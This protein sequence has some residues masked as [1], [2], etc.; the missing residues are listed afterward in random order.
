MKLKAATTAVLALSIMAVSSPSQPPA[1][2][3]TV[4]KDRS[5]SCCKNWI[6][7]LQANGFKV[8]VREVDATKPYQQQYHVPSNLTSCHTAVVNGYTVEGH[9]PARE[10]KKLLSEKPKVR[11]LT[12]PGMPIGSP[13][14]EG[15]KRQS[16]AVLTFTDAGQTSV[17][18][19]YPAP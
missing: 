1:D 11:G 14:M 9:V 19:N 2:R 3:V 10:I 4:Y 7:H 18:A 5:C 8:D 17:Y 16:F 12:V 6:A 15:G 13:G